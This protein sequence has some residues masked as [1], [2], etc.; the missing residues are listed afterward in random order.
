MLYIK[1]ILKVTF[2]EVVLLGTE[3]SRMDQVQFVEGSL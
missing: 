1:P 3:Y 2:V